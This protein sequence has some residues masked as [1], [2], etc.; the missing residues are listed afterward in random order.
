[1]RFSGLVLDNAPDFRVRSQG[2]SIAEESHA[3]HQ[4]QRTGHA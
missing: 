3:A 2:N 1:M 4:A